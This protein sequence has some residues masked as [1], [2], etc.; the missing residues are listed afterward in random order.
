MRALTPRAPGAPIALVAR[1]LSVEQLEAATRLLDVAQ[2]VER[3][4]LSVRFWR[5]ELAAGGIASVKAG[6]RRVV[7]EAALFAWV[8]ARTTPAEP[9][10]SSHSYRVHRAVS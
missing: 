9:A 2:L 4:G 1:G 7:T 3:T 5:A 8:A 6:R 10:A